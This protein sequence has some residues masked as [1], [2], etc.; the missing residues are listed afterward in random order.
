[1]KWLMSKMLFKKQCTGRVTSISYLGIFGGCLLIEIFFGDDFPCFQILCVIRG[2]GS[3]I[4][5]R[6]IV[7]SRVPGRIQT[8]KFEILIFVI[9]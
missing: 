1:M 5:L 7:F 4:V 2:N 3:K 9:S 6:Y 8:W